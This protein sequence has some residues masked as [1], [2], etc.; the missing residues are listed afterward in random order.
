MKNRYSKTR[1]S[2]S[3]LILISMAAA[4]LLSSGVALADD[5]TPAV[6]PQSAEEPTATYTPTPTAT[7]TTTAVLDGASGEATQT[8]AAAA[9]DTPAE[10]DDSDEIPF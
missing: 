8:P 6:E 3:L 4:S 10:E 5:G 7:Q 9:S 1:T 2:L